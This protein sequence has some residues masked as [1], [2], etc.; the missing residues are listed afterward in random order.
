VELEALAES[1]VVVLAPDLRGF[2]ETQFAT[3]SSSDW[4]RLLGD[5][6]SAMTAMLTGTTLVGMRSADVIRAINLLAKRPDVDPARI[7]A[8]GRDGAAIPLLHAAVLDNRIRKIVLDGMLVSYDAVIRRNVNRGI[9]E[10]VIPGVLKTYDLPDLVAGLAPR[11]VLIADAVDPLGTQLTSAE[12]Q[13]EYQRAPAARVI[14]RGPED[15]PGTAY[16]DFI[17]TER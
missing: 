16:R 7:S 17:V 9:F 13:K 2:G 10:H 8:V 5:Y 12:S 14:R 11:P 15:Q 4:N 3:D 1:G 6:N